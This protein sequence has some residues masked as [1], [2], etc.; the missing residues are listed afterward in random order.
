MTVLTHALGRLLALDGRSGPDSP[1]KAA[2]LA[3]V[4]QSRWLRFGLGL[5]PDEPMPDDEVALGAAAETFM[6]DWQTWMGFRRCLIEVEPKG[7]SPIAFRIEGKEPPP[8]TFP[9]STLA[10]LTAWNPGGVQR[11]NEQIN[12]RANARLAAH[13]DARM[14]E[15]WPAVMAPGSR[16]REEGFAVLGL[17]RD[18]AW[19]LAEAFGQLAIYYIDAGTPWLVARL[20]GRVVSW[21]GR[22]ASVTR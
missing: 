4:S 2:L 18:E 10:I 1:D 11:S 19:R 14:V 6:R 22:L 5:L 13:L 8:E 16:W 20:R 7:G 12:R 21:A 17:D 3:A 9:A 15:R